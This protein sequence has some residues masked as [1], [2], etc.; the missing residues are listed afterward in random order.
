MSLQHPDTGKI[1]LPDVLSA[2][3]DDTRLAIVGHLARSGEACMTCGQ[4]LG[5][6]SKTSLS[7]HLAKLREAGVIRVE[8]RGTARFVSLRREDLE[9]RFPGFLDSVLAAA[10]K[11][12]SAR[13]PS[14]GTTAAEPAA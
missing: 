7:Y 2:L 9:A 1:S 6:T 14:D 8:P 13:A 3:G 4:F 12:S 10:M 11:L 5:I